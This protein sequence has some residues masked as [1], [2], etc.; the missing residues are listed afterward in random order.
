MGN[1][2]CAS[3]E[4]ARTD[5]E[6]VFA[7]RSGPR[8]SLHDAL[9]P[10]L[11]LDMLREGNQRYVDEAGHGHQATDQWRNSLA[12]DGQR[13]AAA[14][15]GCADS[16][17]PVE[18]LFDAQPGDLFVLR[19]AGNSCS[20]AEGSIVGSV[21]YA[22]GHL[23]TK[24]ILVLGHTRCGAIAGA[25]KAMLA[26]RRREPLAGQ[27]GGRASLLD[28]LLQGLAPV[29]LQAAS[30]LG[31]GAE[32]D[33]VAAHAVKVNI[34]NT[35]DKLLEYSRLLRSKVELGEVEVHGGIY[36]LASGKVE[37]LGQRL[38]RS[39]DVHPAY[40]TTGDA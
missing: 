36:D 20:H 23:G 15:V 34:F 13:P 1:S 27:G 31:P 40:Q 9:P 14:V 18:L 17:C 25:T 37:F 30:E 28:S 12:Q 38:G 35:M 4:P 3:R 11:A 24:L 29:A 8:T 16:R 21:E 26:G 6:I 39:G 22:I 33:A 7:A 5:N 32:E 19:N 2:C 10:A